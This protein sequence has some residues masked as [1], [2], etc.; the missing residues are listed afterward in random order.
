M[1]LLIDSDSL[2]Y[3]A[4]FVANEEG[5]EAL[6]CYQAN[7]SIKRILQETQ[8]DTYQLYLSGSNNFRYKIYPEYKANRVDMK[9]PIHLQTIREHLVGEW[10]ATVTDGI[11][12]DDAVVIAQYAGEDTCI[13]H[14]DKDIDQAAGKHYNPTK[15]LFYDVSDEQGMRHFYYQL[16]MGDRADNI[17]GF[18]GKMRNAVPKFLQPRIDELL[19]MS[20]PEEMLEHVLIMWG[21]YDCDPQRLIEF[22]QA[23]HCL[24]MQRKEEDDWRNYLNDDTM[25]DFGLPVGSI[26]LLPAPFEQQAD[27]GHQN[28]S[29]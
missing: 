7:E 8:C 19:D 28:L 2:V 6:A 16:I 15:K 12:A 3:A 26:R 22:N 24:W 27:V 13:S 25:T 18:D 20:L 29:V 1:H 17:L 9:R 11:E 23:A 10:G 4:G 5:Q 14:V 21:G